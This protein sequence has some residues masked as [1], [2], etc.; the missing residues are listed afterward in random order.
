YNQF[1]VG[2]EVYVRLKGLFIGE[3]RSG[4]DIIA[5][6]GS[7]DGE[8]VD[9]ITANMIPDFIFRS[10]V[11]EA[12]V[13]LDVNFSDI[14]ESHIGLM[15]SVSNAQ[16]P[17]EFIGE[18]FVNPY[19]DFDTQYPMESCDGTGSLLL[20]TSS[21]A[22][23]AQEP[24]PTD[25]RGTVTG[26]ITK[27][28]NGSDLVMVFNDTDGFEPT[29]NRCDPLF[30]DNFASNSLD[31][32][33]PYS[34]TGAQTWSVTSFGNPGPSAYM[35]GFSGGAQANEDWLI[36]K[37]ID[38]SGITA[39]VL[40]FDSV[41]RYSGDA[42]EVY[43]ATTYN[44]G[45]PNTDGDWTPLAAT[46]DTNEGSWSSWTSSGNVDVS[47]AAGGQLYIAFKYV[48]SVYAAAAYE[49]D[50]VVVKEQ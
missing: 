19:D 34:V 5:I 6:G 29:G 46:F 11:T 44:G 9:E 35:S 47:A 48:S 7:S 43:M 4:D 17:Q 22:N 20:E 3:T 31:N 37:P 32:W 39:P 38:L 33:T 42:L 28:F 12:V 41:K 49:I 25:G 14:D 26:I 27:T 15:V 50:N 45:D 13:P 8:A 1:N 18:L 36:S 30:A 16:F 23:F 24:L 40:I 21:F 10:S 2:R